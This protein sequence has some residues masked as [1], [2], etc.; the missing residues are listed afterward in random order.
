MIDLMIEAFQFDFFIRA[1][2]IGS[3]LAVVYALLGNF[4]VLRN[5]AIVGHSMANL[6]FLGAAIASLLS[7][8]LYGLMIIVTLIGVLFI[9]FLQSS[10]SI[11]RDSVLAFTSQLSMAIAIITLSFIQGYQNIE[12]FLFGSILAVSKNDLWITLVFSAIIL[13]VLRFTYFPLL[14]TV[15]NPELSQS[16]KINIHRINLIFMTTLALAIVL[17]VKIIGVILLAAFLVI[18]ANIAKNIASNL[19]QM[20]LLST[21]FG[22]L[23]VFFGLVFSYIL[24]A[25]SGA[26]IIL[27]LGAM[28]MATHLIKLVR[29]S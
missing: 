28:L 16:N 25:P 24:D 13:M 18:P 22:I 10:S 20:F 8:N 9:H 2:I 7:W 27:I 4:V 19:R 21:L 1:L 23:G 15:I 14:Q 17:G 3:A 5:E 29:K 26:M 6:A 11:N 12:G